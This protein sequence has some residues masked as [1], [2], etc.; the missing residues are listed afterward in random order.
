MPSFPLISADSHIVEPPDM[1]TEPDRSETAQP[2]AAHGAAQ[3]AG[4]AANTT[5]GCSTG[6]RSAPWAP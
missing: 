3:D 2:R 1:Y 6:S 4:R 5:P